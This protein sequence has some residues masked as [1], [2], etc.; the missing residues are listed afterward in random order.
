MKR[1]EILKFVNLLSRKTKLKCIGIIALAMVNAILSSVW[2]VR[3]SDI[4]TSISSGGIVS[5]KS[6]LVLIAQ[7]GLIYLSA[8]CIS[9]VRRV[10]LDCI[11]ASQEAETRAHSV[12]KLLKMPVAYCTG[13][14]SAERT[15]Q[16]NQGVAGLSQLIKIVCNDIFATILTAVCTLAQVL[17][18]AHWV[19]G[20][21]MMLYLFFT[22]AI[23]IFQIRSQN[24]IREKIVSQK[25]ALDGQI[26]ESIS[27]LELIRGMNAET[28]ERKRLS[29]GILQVS[30]TEMQHHCY[31]GKYDC[32]KQ[33]CK[34]TFQM[35]ILIVAII[36]VLSGRMA[37][38]A[39]ITSCLLFQQLIK[40]IDEVYRFM[41]ETASSVVK[42]KT[43]LEVMTQPQDKVFSYTGGNEPSSDNT[44]TLENVVISS[45]AESSKDFKPLAQ[46]DHLIIPTDCKVALQGATGCGKTTM[47]RAIKRFYPYIQGSISLFGKKLES[48]SQRELAEFICYVPQSTFFFAGSIRDNLT[49]G[50]DEEVSDEVLLDALAKA[51]LLDELIHTKDLPKDA[52]SIPVS[53]GG[54]NFSGGQRQRLALARAFLRTPRLYL[55][56]ESTANLDAATTDR[57]LTN[58][59]K[60][61]AEHHAGIVYISHD[62]HV[63]NRCDRI[64]PVVNLLNAHHVE[65][66]AASSS[67]C[68]P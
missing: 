11:I 23:S 16:L 50:M 68:C 57:V 12:E 54:K 56:D 30:R 59:E 35:A 18:K 41:D 55:L 53:E 65:N 19:M 46:Y 6:G 27:N 47:I 39:V 20:C 32:L 64:I 63:V 43:L 15:A 4:Y 62:K 58:I 33:V 26:S 67:G 42:A 3:L 66:T 5:I 21:I 1:T 36:M 61:A 45:P 29:P 17:L 38:G 60:Y 51:C 7:F 28:Y 13:R 49:Y 52:L 8:E 10:F 9:I 40:P 24:G 14:L 2:P 25:T 48:Y 22:V 31:M 34:I 37:V 44:I